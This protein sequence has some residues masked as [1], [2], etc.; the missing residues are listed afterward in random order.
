MKRILVTLTLALAGASAQAVT[1]PD[2]AAQTTDPRCVARSMPDGAGTVGSGPTFYQGGSEQFRGGFVTPDGRTLYLALETLRNTDPFGVVMAVDLTTGDRRVVSGYL[3]TIERVGKGLKVQGD[4]DTLD[5]YTLGNIFDVQPLPDG[6]L[7]ANTGQLIRI[8]PLSGDRTLL[9]TPKTAGDTRVRDTVE[10]KYADPAPNRAGQAAAPSVPGSVNTP[11]GN[12]S[13]GGFL[14]GLLGGQKPAA[15]AQAQAP[16]APG[17]G[18]FCTQN[19]PAPLP[20]IPHTY[21]STDAQGNVF[22][23]GSNN[24]L[25]AGFALFKLDAKND[26]RCSAVSRFDTDGENI[27]GSGIPWTSS[28]AGT[29][30]IFGNFAVDGDTLYA[31]GGPNPNYIVVSVNTRTGERRLISGQTHE[32]GAQAF[33]KGQG[34]AHIGNMLAFSGGT[35]YTTQEQ[36]LDVP[37]SLVRID[38]ATGNRTLIQPVK[39]SPL[40]KGAARGSTLY[41]VPNSPLLI[42]GFNGALHVLDPRSGQ[43]AVLSR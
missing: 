19:A 36:V 24:P 3:N 37:F 17:N 43:N 40:S 27:L 7:V 13:V 9:W 31:A 30:P 2:C 5:L 15:P 18:Y 39:G 20:A 25:G 23:L 6:S 42:V 34:D 1:L 26:Y 35:L 33:K 32:G 11:I 8:D 22:M 28:T 4:R 12:I 21:L 38:P 41:A 16:V 10:K 29:G 14:G